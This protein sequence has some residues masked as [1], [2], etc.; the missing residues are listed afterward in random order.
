MRCI[1]SCFC[2]LDTLIAVFQ[3]LS[4]SPSCP[5]DR[6][7][8]SSDLIRTLL[9]VASGVLT[10]NKNLNISLVIK[11]QKVYDSFNKQLTIQISKKYSNNY[12]SNFVN[13]SKTLSSNI[14]VL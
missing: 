6:P 9:N 13:S 3:I 5:R 10:I 4:D 12:S 1:I 7:T 8:Q 14:S 2:R 11:Y